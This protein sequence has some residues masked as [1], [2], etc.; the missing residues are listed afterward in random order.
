[1]RTIIFCIFAFALGLYLIWIPVLSGN[2]TSVDKTCEYVDPYTCLV[3]SENSSEIKTVDISHLKDKSF[4]VK[5]KVVYAT[6][7]PE[8]KALRATGC[9][10]L[11]L[12][13]IL[14]IRFSFYALADVSLFAFFH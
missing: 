4:S 9:L 2:G 6:E 3:R 12:L 13:I 10:V 14:L 11:L 7:G 5:E 1:M 8:Q